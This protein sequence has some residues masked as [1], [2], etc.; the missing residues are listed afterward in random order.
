MTKKKFTLD[1]RK[2]RLEFNEAWLTSIS[3]QLLSAWNETLLGRQKVTWTFNL[4]IFE[5]KKL[6][7]FHLLINIFYSSWII[8]DKSKVSIFHNQWNHLFKSCPQTNK[9]WKKLNLKLGKNFRTEEN[10]LDIFRF[11]R[12]MKIKLYLFIF[13]ILWHVAWDDFLRLEVSDEILKLGQTAVA[14]VTHPEVVSS[15][16]LDRRIVRGFWQPI[17]NWIH[18]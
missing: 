6:K 18:V 14:R 11:F 7:T 1:D 17:L 10:F 15:F 4:N 9:R 16:A 2:K 12:K 3:T 13:H 5:K 8:F